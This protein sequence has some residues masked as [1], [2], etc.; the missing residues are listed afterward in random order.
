MGQKSEDE[1]EKDAE[2]D[3]EEADERDDAEGSSDEGSEDEADESS[4]D[5][6]EDEASDED[7]ADASSEDEDE[8]SDS[9]EDEAAA[10]DDAASGSEDA[11][12]ARSEEDGEGDE[13][14]LPTQL[15][16]GRFVFA[17]FFGGAI[18]G[19]YVL[20]KSIHGLWAHFANRDFFVDNAPMLAGLPD[21]TK[22]TYA[23]IV[24]AV[25]AVLFVFR[26]YRRQSVRDWSEAVS[27]E[28]V[29]VKWPNR[30]E[31]QSSTF[32]VLATSAVATAYLF[33]MDRFWG[34]VT[35]LIYGTGGS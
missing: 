30:K 3:G 34:F 11:L 25:I 2:R 24:G 10:K 20:G 5:S 16:S 28:L 13:E 12:A 18:V 31:V 19:A 9:D 22:E 35:D 4:S 29:K 8:A 6:D 1:D 32:V 17:A 23:M 14:A 15:G 7:D 33:L 21:E 27:A 26:T